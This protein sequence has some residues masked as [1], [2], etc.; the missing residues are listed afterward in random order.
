MDAFQQHMID[1][2]RAVRLGEAPP[3]LPGRY[4]LAVIRD[5]R[6]RRRFDAVIAGRP[7]RRR[8][9]TALRGLLHRPRRS[10]PPP[11]PS[12]A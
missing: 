6:E 4:D 5:L 8:W 10:G 3:P 11:G 7:A 2:Y 12:G 1:S 9:R